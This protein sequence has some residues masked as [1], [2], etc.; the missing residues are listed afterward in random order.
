[1]SKS[2]PE[3]AEELR[4]LVESHLSRMSPEAQRRFWALITEHPQNM[5]HKKFL[6]T[7]REKVEFLGVTM[8][9]ITRLYVTE[10]NDLTA[11]IKK[12]RRPVKNAERD[13]EIMRLHGEGKT[14]GQ[15]VM[16]LAGRW[17]LTD[18]KVTAVISR[19]RKKRQQEEAD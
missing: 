12:H 8:D 7:L 5:H 2:L 9:Q 4:A 6:A 11:K 15:I 13:A 3:T 19:Q 1:M 18:R 16:T 17:K 14:A 10:T